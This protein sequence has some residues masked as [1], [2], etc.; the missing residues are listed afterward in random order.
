M[1]R[2]TVNVSQAQLDRVA[3]LNRAFNQ[4]ARRLDSEAKSC[5]LEATIML[6]I[7]YGMQEL[8]R[9]WYRSEFVQQQHGAQPVE[10]PTQAQADEHWPLDDITHPLQ[11]WP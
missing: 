7:E 3:Q 8:R 1:P 5:A 10:L 4:R 6:A 11:V 2:I 9:V